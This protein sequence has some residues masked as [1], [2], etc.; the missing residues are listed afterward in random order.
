MTRGTDSGE[1]GSLIDMKVSS[2]TVDPFTNMP[3][4]ILKDSE[5]RE[6]VP[7]WIGLMEASAIATELENIQ[8]DRPMTH[9]LMAV[10]LRRCGIKVDRIEVHD[11]RDNTFFA[12]IFLSGANGLAVSVDARPSDALALA[13]RTGAG[14][15]VARKVVDK[16]RRIDLRA[17]PPAIDLRCEAKSADG[18]LGSEGLPVDAEAYRELLECLGDSAFGK[19]KM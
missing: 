17:V 12:T 14:I 19:W 15:R 4:V 2:L 8:L 9:D 16:A 3:I 7:I 5:G 18:F 13:L 10:V 1:D 6:A 11:L